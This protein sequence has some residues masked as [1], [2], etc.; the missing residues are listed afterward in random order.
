MACPPTSVKAVI[1]FICAGGDRLD[2]G[3]TA[4]G[5][6]QSYLFRGGTGEG[7]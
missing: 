4:G 2:A 3:G 1:G 7:L 5:T 6:A